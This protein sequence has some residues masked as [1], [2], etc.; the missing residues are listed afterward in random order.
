MK[1][2]LSG[3]LMAGCALFLFACTK[4]DSTPSQVEMPPPPLDTTVSSVKYVGNFENGPYGTTR[5][6][7]KVVLTAGKW[8]LRLEGF[9]VSSGP[10]LKV[11]IS[12][13]RLPLNFIRLGSVKAFNGEQVYDI[14]G[15]PDYM[16]YPFALIHCEQFNHLFG[17]A[18]LVKQ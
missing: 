18:M 17:A 8:Q 11:Y 14:P 4:A 7:A 9:S 12:K 13:E 10:D 5:G 3:L 15:N 6:T 1:K 2:L 16:E